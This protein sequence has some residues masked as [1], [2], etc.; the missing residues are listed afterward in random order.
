MNREDLI[1]RKNKYI[2]IH[3]S[4]TTKNN[5]FAKNICE[6]KITLDNGLKKLR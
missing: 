1:Y 6:G 4:T 5:T 2:Y 3:F